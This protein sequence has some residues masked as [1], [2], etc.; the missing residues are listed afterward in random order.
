MSAGCRW[1]RSNWCR[2]AT[3]SQAFKQVSPATE[4]RPETRT[5]DMCPCR[6][7][8]RTPGGCSAVGRDAEFVALW[9]LHYGPVW[10]DIWCLPMIIYD[11]TD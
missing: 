9:V 11:I 5:T 3:V 7:Q 1:M 6:P 8:V 4:V 10:P 2:V